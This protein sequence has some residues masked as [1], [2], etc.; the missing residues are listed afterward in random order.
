MSTKIAEGTNEQDHFESTDGIRKYRELI[1]DTF[2]VK[3]VRSGKM[4]GG[5]LTLSICIVGRGG[6]KGI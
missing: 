4:K 5:F 2:A 1:S 3:T 6:V